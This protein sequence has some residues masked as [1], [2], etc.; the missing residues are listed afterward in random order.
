M[1]A[2]QKKTGEIG[3]NPMRLTGEAHLKRLRESRIESVI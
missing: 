2:I 3:E 1:S